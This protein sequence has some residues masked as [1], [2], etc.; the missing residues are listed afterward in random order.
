MKGFLLLNGLPPECIDVS[1]GFC[2]CSAGAYVWA[3]K[4][5]IKPDL[6]VGDF[7]SLGFVPDDCQTVVYP[8]MKNETDGE[9]ALRLLKEKG[10]DS[11]DV[12]GAFGKRTDHFL[13]NL[14][15]LGI[16]M[17][18]GVGVRLVGDGEIIFLGTGQVDLETRKNRTISLVPYGDTA[19]IIDSKG[20][21]YPLKDLVL[22]RDDTR[23]ISNVAES[24]KVGFFVKEGRVLV[25][26]SWRDE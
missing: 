3:K 6:V 18:L 22:K 19:H 16:G 15:L 14:A 1:G 9:I 26:E 10:C 7:D 25:L 23:G 17:D 4:M 21:L 11:V 20:L 13:G 8:V 2:V 5:G 24:E 12:Y